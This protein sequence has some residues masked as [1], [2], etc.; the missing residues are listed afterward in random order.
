[1]K[2]LFATQI[3]VSIEAL[4]KHARSPRVLIAARVAAKSK[5]A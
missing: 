2:S 5:G 1:V 4:I 3:P